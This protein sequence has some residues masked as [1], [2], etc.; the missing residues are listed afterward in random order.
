V[1]ADKLEIGCLLA[2][3]AARSSDGSSVPLMAEWSDRKTGSKGQVMH[4]HHLQRGFS[5]CASC[6]A[7]AAWVS[8]VML[9]TLVIRNDN[10]DAHAGARSALADMY[11]QA[12]WWPLTDESASSAAL[13]SARAA[14][15]A[16]G[17]YYVVGLGS[18]QHCGKF[19]QCTALYASPTSRSTG[20]ALRLRPAS[21]RKRSSVGARPNSSSAVSARMFSPAANT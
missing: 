1:A 19:P 20:A 17:R 18:L 7:D 12:E 8:C 15:R 14:A 6:L 11:P 3:A 16:V 10:P 4:L 9:I 21:G 5:E 13:E 2:W